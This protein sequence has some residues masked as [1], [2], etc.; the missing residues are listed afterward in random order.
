MSVVPE[1][2]QQHHALVSLLEKLND[3][4]KNNESLESVERIIDDVISYTN[5]HFAAEE[6]LMAQYDYPLIDAHKVKHRQLVH[7]AFK[8]KEK[9][10]HIGEPEFTDWF[11]HWPFSHI[12]AHIVHADRQLE[13][14]I[15]NFRAKKP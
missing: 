12:H 13:E 4:A 1:M 10:R 5:F 3:A 9:L 6:R 14:H 15:A 7:D 8:F 2:E 11:R